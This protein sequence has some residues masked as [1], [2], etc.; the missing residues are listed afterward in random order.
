MILFHKFLVRSSPVA[1]GGTEKQYTM[2]ADNGKV[3]VHALR[4]TLPPSLEEP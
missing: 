4:A 1:H 3:Y 2:S